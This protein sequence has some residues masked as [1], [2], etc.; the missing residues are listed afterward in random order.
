ML[1]I[2]DVAPEFT[3]TTVDGELFSLAEARQNS[4]SVLLVFLRHLG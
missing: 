2:G 3:L 4:R 1:R